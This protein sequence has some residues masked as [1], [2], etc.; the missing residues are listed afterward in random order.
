MTASP[1][2][3]RRI[4]KRE[5]N[6]GTYAKAIRYGRRAWCGESRADDERDGDEARPSRRLSVQATLGP[7]PDC[8]R[9]GYAPVGV[10][11]RIRAHIRHLL[12]GRRCA[13]GRAAPHPGDR[14]L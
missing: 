11:A 9:E 1:Q 4:T 8:D 14:L 6:R 7:A 5:A 2:A 3:E 12:H 10:H 13:P